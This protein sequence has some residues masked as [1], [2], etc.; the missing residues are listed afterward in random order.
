MYPE[1]CVTIAENK[2]LAFLFNNSQKY[3]CLKVVTTYDD[4]YGHACS[5]YL[6][7]IE[8]EFEKYIT[9]IYIMIFY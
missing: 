5:T 3:F 6:V 2:I 8:F 7:D 9:H 4:I 1:I